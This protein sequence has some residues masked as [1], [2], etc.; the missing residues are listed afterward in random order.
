MHNEQNYLSIIFDQSSNN[1]AVYILQTLKKV[2]WFLQKQT[3]IMCAWLQVFKI[4]C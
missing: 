3:A 1:N 4:F 2:L